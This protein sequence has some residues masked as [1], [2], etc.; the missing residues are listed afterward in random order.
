MDNNE[1]SKALQQRIDLIKI[2]ISHLKYT[3]PEDIEYF[4]TFTEAKKQE[5]Y[6]FIIDQNLKIQALEAELSLYK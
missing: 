5:I 4:E 2:S 3:E 6:Q 1:K